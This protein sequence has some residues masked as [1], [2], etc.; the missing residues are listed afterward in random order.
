VCLPKLGVVV[1][2]HGVILVALPT[3]A[4]TAGATVF[5]LGGNGGLIRHDLRQQPSPYQTVYSL[6]LDN[7]TEWAAYH[8][9][10]NDG[11]ITVLVHDRCTWTIE[12]RS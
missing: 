5:A 12:G 11:V 3:A 1:K 8:N 2:L 10:N 4:I 9:A 7:G 6:C